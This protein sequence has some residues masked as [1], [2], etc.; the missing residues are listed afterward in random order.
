MGNSKE[1]V[2]DMLIRWV[3]ESEA[4]CISPFAVACDELGIDTSLG[5][6]KCERSV[7]R[8]MAEAMTR[9]LAMARLEGNGTYGT[10]REFMRVYSILLE[11]PMSDDE[12]VEGWLDR[13]FV[14]K[15]VGDDGEPVQLGDTVVDKLRGEMLVTR[16]SWVGNGVYFNG[17]H[18]RMGKKL[19]TSKITYAPGELVKRPKPQVLD[20][21]GVPVKAGDAVWNV[22]DDQRRTVMGFR[23]GKA[24]TQSESGLEFFEAGHELTHREP[25]TQER[26]DRD[27][28]KLYMDYWECGHVE[29]RD[30]PAVIDGK[31]PCARYGNASDC[32]DA[33]RLDLLRRQRELDGRDA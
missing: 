9:E 14:P 11:K 27:A 33:Q 3:N 2:G 29:C 21:D 16:M 7:Y 15:P 5:Y 28:V 24:H 30:C 32:A 19:R 25:D 23:D 6:V 13:W 26:I 8:R 1:T 4:R 17:S 12:D 31:T 10:L 18:D 20:A 22:F